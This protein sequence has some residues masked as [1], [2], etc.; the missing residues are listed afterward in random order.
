MLPWVVTVTRYDLAVF[1]AATARQFK[2][3]VPQQIRAHAAHI[4]KIER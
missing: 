1:G 2:I 3:P 4:I